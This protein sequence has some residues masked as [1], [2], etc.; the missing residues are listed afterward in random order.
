MGEPRNAQISLPRPGPGPKVWAGLPGLPR[1]WAPCPPP[2]YTGCGGASRCPPG[3]PSINPPNSG[4]PASVAKS[5]RWARSIF[6]FRPSRSAFSQAAPVAKLANRGPERL[7]S[8]PQATKL[9]GAVTG[10]R[11]QA[12]QVS[13]APIMS[14]PPTYWA[15]V[16]GAETHQAHLLTSQR[17]RI[18]GRQLSALVFEGR[19]GWEMGALHALGNQ[20]F[21]RASTPGTQ[22]HSPKPW[23]WTGGTSADRC[24]PTL[25]PSAAL[26]YSHPAP[27]PRGLSISQNCGGQGRA[28]PPG[29]EQCRD[30]TFGTL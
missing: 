12:D 3:P 16:W 2:A 24:P 27:P 22:H 17:G 14:L 28:C 7:S 26:A 18:T 10:I 25:P 23:P 15:T 29:V 13:G 30:R 6:L 8:L 11:F 5:F 4:S 1:V 9:A 21:L 20:P 19:G